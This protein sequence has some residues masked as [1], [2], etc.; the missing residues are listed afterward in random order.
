MPPNR[1][2]KE[3]FSVLNDEEVE[4]IVVGAHALIYY[5]EPRFTRDLDIWVNPSPENAPRVYNALGRFGAPL[6]DVNPED[7][8][9]KELVLQLGVPP[10]RIDILMG[11]T[12]VEFPEAWNNRV[13]T[14]YAGIPIS[15]LGKCQIIK[16]KKA[17]GRPQDLI[18]VERLEADSTQ[19][20]E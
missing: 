9:N 14:T 10:N 7:F 8:T 12:G 3:M 17:T 5:A 4:Y 19:E 16:N 18:D 20:S 1:D 11:I 15:I 6:A 13:R 2:F